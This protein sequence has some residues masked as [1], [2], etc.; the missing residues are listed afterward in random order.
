MWGGAVLVLGATA[1]VVALA[2]ANGSRPSTAGQ[3]DGFPPDVMWAILDHCDPEDDE[4]SRR[5]EGWYIDFVGETLHVEVQE[6]SRRT[7]EAAAYVREVNDCLAD[8]R[9]ERAQYDYL[10]PRITTRADRLLA[11]EVANRWLIPCVAKHH[12]LTDFRRSLSD[13]LDVERAPWFEFYGLAGVEF[14][15]M[16]AARV[17]C[18]VSS[19][20]YE[21]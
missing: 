5:I 7:E 1:A 18:G 6:P 16:L 9:I 11:F 13:Y 15:D 2:I 21:L 8:Y 4:R 12:A 14:D 19:Q 3:P 17:A 20:P 10:A